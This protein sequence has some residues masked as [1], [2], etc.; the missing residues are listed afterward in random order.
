MRILITLAAAA[1]LM[2]GLVIGIVLAA[3]MITKGAPNGAVTLGGTSEGML[4]KVAFAV[5]WVLVAG[6][7]TGLIGSG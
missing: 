7:A 4:S 3:S 1:A 2:A 6:V 5:L